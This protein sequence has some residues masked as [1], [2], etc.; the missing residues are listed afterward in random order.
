MSLHTDLEEFSSGLPEGV[1]RDTLLKHA[2]HA[3]QLEVKLM[4]AE[5]ALRAAYNAAAGALDLKTSDNQNRH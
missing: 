2:E 1:V 4:L 3:R 5:A